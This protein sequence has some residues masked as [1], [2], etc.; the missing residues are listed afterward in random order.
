MRSRVGREKSCLPSNDFN[1]Q[2]F[3]SLKVFH[4]SPFFLL[5]HYNDLGN[6]AVLAM[7]HMNG[8]IPFEKTREQTTEAMHLSPKTTTAAYN[9][10]NYKLTGAATLL[11]DF[12]ILRLS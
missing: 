11:N 2:I 3:S 9:E 7:S 4:L 5:T 6:V 10:E 8:S 12:S 1:F